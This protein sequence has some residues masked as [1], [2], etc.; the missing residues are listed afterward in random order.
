[1]TDKTIII[2]LGL[3][4]MAITLVIGSLYQDI[5]TAAQICV[6]SSNWTY[7]QCLLELTR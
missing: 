2:A 5:E 4:L 3:T 1:M 7:E 6:E